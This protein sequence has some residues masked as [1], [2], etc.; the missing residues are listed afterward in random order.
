MF[1]FHE[2]WLLY[3]QL[4]LLIQN[5]WAIYSFNK[6][7]VSLDL[8]CPCRLCYCL[9][10]MGPDGFARILSFFTF[11]LSGLHDH[12]LSCKVRVWGL[13]RRQGSYRYRQVDSKYHQIFR[14]FHPPQIML[15]IKVT[16]AAE[17]PTR[18]ALRDARGIH[19]LSLKSK[20]YIR[21]WRG[22]GKCLFCTFWRLV[23]SSWQ[24]PLME[25]ICTKSENLPKLDSNH[26][27]NLLNTFWGKCVAFCLEGFFLQCKECCNEA[28]LH[29]SLVLR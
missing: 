25:V 13:W 29:R 26:W 24:T 8:C 7:I 1:L 12:A 19:L 6:K 4:F 16:L 17:L 14:S 21:T 27:P 28:L 20:C 22:V 15:S 2:K 11:F 18:P 3:R 10:L 23:V 5:D 9:C